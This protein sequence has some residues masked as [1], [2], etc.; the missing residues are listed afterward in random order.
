[1]DGML[2]RSI[3]LLVRRVITIIP[4]VVIVG[5]GIDPTQALIVSQVILSFGIPFALI[6]LL[7]ATSNRKIMGDQIN[8][9]AITVILST[10]VAIIV[11][12]NLALIWLTFAE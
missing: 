2:N 8:H 11:L 5:F 12:L 7:L 6:P 9:K 1:M 10:I 3:P 4:A